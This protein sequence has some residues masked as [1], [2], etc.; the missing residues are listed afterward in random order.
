MSH[1]FKAG[2]LAMVIESGDPADIGKS[3]E[4]VCVLIDDKDLHFF[5]GQAF[6]GWADHAPCAFIIMD[7]E[8]WM[9]QQKNLMPLRGDFEPDREKAQELV[10]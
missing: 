8:I 1:Q 7:G 10:Q 2:D 9:W 3:V 5:R 4:I 6:Q